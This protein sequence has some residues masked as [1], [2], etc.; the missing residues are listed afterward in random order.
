MWT[1]DFRVKHR[2]EEYGPAYFS[3]VLE[4]MNLMVCG[5]EVRD[6]RHLIT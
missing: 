4:P 1:P 2:A 3:G 5:L 6:I